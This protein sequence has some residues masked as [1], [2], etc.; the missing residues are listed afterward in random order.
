MSFIENINELLKDQVVGSSIVVFKDNELF[1]YNYGLSSMQA[2]KKVEDETL[3]RIASISKIVVSMAAMKLHE[4][5]MLNIDDDL[6]NIFDFVIRNPHYPDIP[7][8]TKMLMLHT[9]SIND[10]YDDE[11]PAYDNLEVGYNGVNGR[12]YS[13]ALEDLLLNKESKYYSDKTY[14]K[15]K[16]GTFFTYSNFGTGILACVVERCSGMRFVEYVEKVFL[17]PLKLDASF[18]A[19]RI[20][21]QDKI[22]DTFYFSKEENEFK[23]MRTGKSFVEKS[24]PDFEVGH[25]FRGPAGGLFISMQDLAKIMQVLMN[26]G[27]Y[28][29]VQILKQETVDL[30]LQMHYLGPDSDYLAKGLQLKFID[31]IDGI[32]FKGHT[33]SAYG[34]SSFMFFSKEDDLGICFIANGGN[35]KDDLAGLNN[36]QAGVLREFVLEF[37]EEK[38][39]KV[40]KFNLN[41]NYAYL[42]GR[43]ILFKEVVKKEGEVYLDLMDFAS[44]IN[45]IPRVTGNV[46]INGK[47][48]KLQNEKIALFKTLELL[49]IE[50]ANVIDNYEIYI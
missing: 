50:Y 42:N 33:G 11:N 45:V 20:I 17:K 29:D 36:I 38:Q 43:K 8:T 44:L 3:F 10:G 41:D 31:S 23:T 4:D 2:N 32:I 1:K 5:G 48:I 35:Y 25:N 30:M 22:S 9:S 28:E 47:V 49:G 6:S 26:D 37:Y 27:K 15:H 46:T 13:V 24:Y 40:A 19:N 12:Y 21:K 18:K 16:P 7:I 14:S 39:S 34:V